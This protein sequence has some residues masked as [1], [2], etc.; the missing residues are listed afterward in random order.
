MNRSYFHIAFVGLAALSLIATLQPQA[1]Q[2]EMRG[3]IISAVALAQECVTFVRGGLIGLTEMLHGWTAPSQPEEL[4]RLHD[5]IRRLRQMLVIEKN[6]NAELERMIDGFAL[7]EDFA[8]AEKMQRTKVVPALIIGRDAT[9]MP[10]VITIDRGADD[11]VRKG[12]GVVWGHAAVGVVGVVRPS[13]SLVH[14]ITSP[15]CRVPAFIQRTGESTFVEGSID[16]RTL[17]M[18]HVFREPAVPGD[19]CLTSGE[20]GSFPRNIL[21]GE[22]TAASFQAGELF[23]EISVRPSLNLA[24]LQTVVVLV[25]EDLPGGAVTATSSL[26]PGN[27]TPP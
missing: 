7:L 9:T 22:V 19:I 13:V 18:R 12:A 21:I 26:R 14:L 11:G 6:K 1:R 8:S 25:R 5:E 10:K 27:S 3:S 2:D 4:R 15:A 16:G 24:A 20:L 17:R 23:Q